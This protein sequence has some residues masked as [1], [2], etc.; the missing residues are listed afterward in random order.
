MEG[1]RKSSEEDIHNIEISSEHLSKSPLFRG[2]LLK[3]VFNYL[4]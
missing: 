1:S 4:T 2:K 3:S